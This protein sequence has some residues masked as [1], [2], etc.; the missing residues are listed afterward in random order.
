ME[1]IQAGTFCE[2][3][4]PMGRRERRGEL[5]KDLGL[6]LISESDPIDNTVTSSSQV[7]F[8]CAGNW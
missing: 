2:E 1:G 5:F 4:Q 8:A 3:L 7:C 6:F